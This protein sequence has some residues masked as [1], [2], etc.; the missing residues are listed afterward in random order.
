MRNI[1]IQCIVETVST[2][3]GAHVSIFYNPKNGKHEYVRVITGGQRNG[4]GMA[5]KLFNDW[6]AILCIDKTITEK[7]YNYWSEGQY[8][9]GDKANEA[10][11][12]LFSV[13]EA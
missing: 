2:R 12:D 1:P 7:E 5:F 9:E 13:V 4:A 3:S 8:M 6:E 11:A 10:L